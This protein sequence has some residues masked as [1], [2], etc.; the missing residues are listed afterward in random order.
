VLAARAIQSLPVELRPVLLGFDTDPAEYVPVAEFDEAQG[1]DS[2][3]AFAFDRNVHFGYHDALTFQVVVSWMI[4]EHK[5]QGLLQ[6]MHNKDAKEFIWVR[7]ADSTGADAAA[8]L[9]FRQ[10]VPA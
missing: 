10:L 9:L 3:C 1:W 4:A 7:H 5:S 2:E 6:T 8:R